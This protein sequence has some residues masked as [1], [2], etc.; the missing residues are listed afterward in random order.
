[1]SFIAILEFKK[2]ELGVAFDVVSIRP[3]D[4]HGFTFNPNPFSGKARGCTA[5]MSSLSNVRHEPLRTLS[6]R[7]QLN[8]VPPIVSGV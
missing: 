6:M 7:E 4:S 1:M 8:H 3:A 2:N 5:L